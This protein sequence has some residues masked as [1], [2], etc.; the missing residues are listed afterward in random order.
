MLKEQELRKLIQE[1]T[2]KEHV[3]D[4]LG[5]LLKSYLEQKIAEYREQIT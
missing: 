3:E 1:V 2:G 4:G 5:I